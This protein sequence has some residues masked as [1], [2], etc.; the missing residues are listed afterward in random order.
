MPALAKSFLFPNLTNPV[1]TSTSINYPGATTTSTFTR[2]SDKQ[3]GNGYYGASNGVHTIAYTVQH[4]FIGTCT[5]QA[6]LATDPI[7]INS[8]NTDWFDVVDSQIEYNLPGYT[9]TNYVNFSGNFVWVRAKVDIDLGGIRF[10]NYN[11]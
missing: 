11:H 2:V 4:N 8:T 7:D 3:P 1:S 9:T 10:I 6:T 5:A